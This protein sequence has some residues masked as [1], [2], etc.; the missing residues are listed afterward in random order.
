[1]RTVALISCCK[2]KLPYKSKVEN[3]YVSESF[4]VNMSKSDLILPDVKYVLSA[5]HGLLKMD[6]EINPYDV[7]LNNMSEKDIIAWSNKVFDQLTCLEDI[8]YTKFIIYADDNYSRHLSKL[9]LHY[10]VIN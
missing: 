10:H 9:L 6:D 2:N 8:P 5:K 4:K 7:T 1:M 3:L